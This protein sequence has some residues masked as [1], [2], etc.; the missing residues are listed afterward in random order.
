MIFIPATVPLGTRLIKF[1]FR[2]C[3]PQVLDNSATGALI[4]LNRCL[5]VLGQVK[6]HW[7]ILKQSLIWNQNL[8]SEDNVKFSQ[9]CCHA[10]CQGVS[11]YRDMSKDLSTR[12][13]WICPYS[14]RNNML[15]R[16]ALLYVYS[17]KYADLGG[18]QVGWGLHLLSIEISGIIL[19]AIL[20]DVCWSITVI[21][22]QNV[23]NN[24]MENR[25]NCV[26]SALWLLMAQ[27]W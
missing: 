4:F 21:W 25:C 16:I 14:I 19:W 11:L 7:N 26:L 23:K 20:N 9:V 10:R 12:S 1:C 15:W 17:V 2:T 5:I 8:W 13:L 22:N 3:N 27:Q 18:V 24:F 6:W